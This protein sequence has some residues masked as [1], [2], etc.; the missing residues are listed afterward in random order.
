MVVIFAVIIV[1]SLI[2]MLSSIT[3][4]YYIYKQY[5]YEYEN[6]E[7][8]YLIFNSVEKAVKNLF[9][10]DDATY[11]SLDE[12]W[13]KQIPFITEDAQINVLIV[14]QERYLNP[15]YLISKNGKDINQTYFQIFS[16]LFDQLNIDKQIIYNIIDWIDTNNVSDGG[17]EHYKDYSTKNSKL[18]SLS[19]LKLIGI[20]DNTLNGYEK[21]GIQYIGLKDILS[22]YTN[23]K[24]N[25]NTCSKQV[26][27]SLD[28][29]IDQNIAEEIISYRKKRAFKRIENLSLVGD[30][31]SDII[32]R[33]KRSNIVDVKSK[34]FLINAEIIYRERKYK[35]QILIR[36]EGN[37]L[38]TV[39]RRLL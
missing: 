28:P 34:N 31:S 14:D 26:L 3:E 5:L 11:D 32:Y 20:D 27:I 29:D 33:L 9:K 17:N 15:N 12:F 39:W 25:I 2:F 4:E 19:E 22:V 18:D 23:G 1:S 13:A 8:I 7:Q 35:L 21:N 24:I 36:R 16:R 6:R 37:S 10:N 30:V 38:K